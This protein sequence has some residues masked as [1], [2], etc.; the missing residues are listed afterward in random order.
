MSCSLKLNVRTA[1]ETTILD[2][3]ARLKQFQ[4]TYASVRVLHSLRITARV[5]ALLCDRLNA[6]LAHKTTCTDGVFWFRTQKQ[7]STLAPS[8]LQLILLFQE[9]DQ[10]PD[11]MRQTISRSSG[12]QL[13]GTFFV[14]EDFMCSGLCIRAGGEWERHFDIAHRIVNALMDALTHAFSLRKPF[15]KLKANRRSMSSY[16]R[17]L[18]AALNE[19]TYIDYLFES[20]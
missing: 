17:K 19:A 3:S 8:F 2:D 5:A 4:K 13:L 14:T 1:H 10:R 11:S 7:E 20:H 16:M 12:P 15:R 6:A 9:A 18:E